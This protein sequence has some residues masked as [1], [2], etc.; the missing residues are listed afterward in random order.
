MQAQRLI[1]SQAHRG[2]ATGRTT[3]SLC[4]YEP[5]S[6]CPPE[7]GPINPRKTR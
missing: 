4:A 3:L 7:P 1:G 5:L 6:L 2:S